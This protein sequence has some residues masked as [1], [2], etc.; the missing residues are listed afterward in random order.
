VHVNERLRDAAFDRFPQER[1]AVERNAILGA[2]AGARER[3][4][5]L[6]ER[7][8]AT[9]RVRNRGPNSRR[10]ARDIR[11][12]P[13]VPRFEDAAAQNAFARLRGGSGQRKNV[14][15]Q[16]RPQQH[17]V[18]VALQADLRRHIFAR[19]FS[20]GSGARTEERTTNAQM[21]VATPVIV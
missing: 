2:A 5:H 3:D 15:E 8:G 16:D 14:S 10:Q 19:D 21:D 1:S 6:A 20:V 12:A 11:R 18:A 4:Q 17:F 7:I 9:Q 13:V